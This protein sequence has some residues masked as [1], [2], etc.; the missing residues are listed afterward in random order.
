M[1]HVSAHK[2]SE[3]LRQAGLLLAEFGFIE[4]PP[5]GFAYPHSGHPTFPVA[6][7]PLASVALGFE[8]A[9]TVP[10]FSRERALSVLQALQQKARLPP[11]NVYLRSV[12]GNGAEQYELYH[13]Y[14]R[15]HMC[16]AVGF[17]HI[18]VAVS[19]MRA[20]SAR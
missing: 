19:P 12:P 1:S 10:H 9:Q 16:L 14:Y 20:E 13:G 11:V 8:R 5:D 15:Y 2:M 4:P 17:T 3:A 18:P 7:V 6:E